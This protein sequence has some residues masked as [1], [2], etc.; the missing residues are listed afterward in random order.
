MSQENVDVARRCLWAF[1]NDTEAFRQTLHPDIE[2]CPFEDGN[3][4]Y[5]GVE[6]A[7]GIRN[8]WLDAWDEHDIAIEDVTEQGESVL[9]SLHLVTRGRESGVEVNVRLHTHFKVR[10]GKIVYAFEYEDR[11]AALEAAG[12]A[13]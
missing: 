10:D 9:A 7:M 4:P 6:A 11:A 5:H 13:E 3:T 2:W 8:G 12:L 1:E